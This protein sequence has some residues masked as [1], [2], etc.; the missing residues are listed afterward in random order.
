[1]KQ[2][3]HR[4]PRFLLCATGAAGALVVVLLACLGLW[5]LDRAAQRTV[6]QQR[7]LAASHAP[8]VALDSSAAIDAAA[9]AGHHIT[10][11]GRWIPE[12]VVYLDNR[13][14]DGAP[15]VYVLMALRLV[16]GRVLVVDRGWMR[17]EPGRVPRS[18]DYRTPNGAVEVVGVAL[19][20]DSRLFALGGAGEQKR[21]GLWQNF[22]FAAF[23]R[24]TGLEVLPI[25]VRADA[26]T[27]A[28]Q[29]RASED[30]LVR[31]WPELGA[32]LQALIDRNH[33]YALQ[34]FAM[35]A[36]LAA[37]LAF[38]GIRYVRRQSGR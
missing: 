19:T 4:H 21:G 35:A 3:W 10:A 36:M 17:R 28:P 7:M 32:P 20:D 27:P 24:V 9:L 13:P 12:A 5:Q 15:G 25:V 37:L 30:G 23:A 34:W 38:Y 1:M 2:L 14:H 11:R 33:G 16:D 31:D 29:D 26:Q 8:A 18:T 22:D 6:L